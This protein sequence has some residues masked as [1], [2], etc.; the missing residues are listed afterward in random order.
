MENFIEIIKEDGSIDYV[1]K[2]YDNINSGLLNIPIDP[3][4]QDLIGLTNEQLQEYIHQ[5]NK[6]LLRRQRNELLTKCDWTQGADS[7]LPPNKKAEWAVYRQQLRDLPSIYDSTNVI[8]P[9]PPQ[10]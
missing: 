5:N 8:W 3:I 10:G 9:T 7:P 4:P 6:E 2:D 1:H